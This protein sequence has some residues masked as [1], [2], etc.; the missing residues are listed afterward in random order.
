MELIKADSVAG[1]VK[2][3][4][5]PTMKDTAGWDRRGARNGKIRH[6]E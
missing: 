2:G 3:L 5:G 1:M 4:M 6:P